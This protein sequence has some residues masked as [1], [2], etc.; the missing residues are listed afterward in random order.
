MEIEF[1][2]KRISFLN[3]NGLPSRTPLPSPSIKC[4]QID[5]G[6]DRGVVSVILR[7]IG[8]LK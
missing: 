7:Q 6:D 8:L 3:D 2:L 4:V 1:S 5:D